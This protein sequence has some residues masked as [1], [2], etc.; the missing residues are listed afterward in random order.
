MAT[1]FYSYKQQDFALMKFLFSK[2]GKEKLLSMDEKNSDS[3]LKALSKVNEFKLNYVLKYKSGYVVSWTPDEKE[4]IS[5][6]VFLLEKDGLY[7]IH[8]FKIK[9]DP[10]FT[11]SMLYLQNNPFLQYR[12][13]LNKSKSVF[14]KS[15]KLKFQ[16]HRKGNFISFWKSGDRFVRLKVQDNK[17]IKS[18]IYIDRNS[19]ASVIDVNFNKKSFSKKGDIELFVIET[20]YPVGSVTKELIKDAIKIKFRD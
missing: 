7:Q 3:M 20:S 8:P 1:L 17:K 12:P 15:S 16:L 13:Q 2:E 5:R 10:V 6:K 4:S 19:Q 18:A 9:N 11:N 14:K